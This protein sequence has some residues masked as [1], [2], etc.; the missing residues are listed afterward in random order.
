MDRAARP[1]FDSRIKEAVRT[2]ALRSPS[3]EVCGLLYS[4]ST[5]CTNDVTG[6][7]RLPNSSP[8]PQLHFAITQRDLLR[9][10]DW[11]AFRDAVPIGTFHSHPGG[12][13]RASGR[14]RRMIRRVGGLHA[15]VGGKGEIRFYRSGPC[16]IS[17]LE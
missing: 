15:I 1:N 9:A 8:L 11:L 16:R 12:E 6:A 14:D 2:A 7:L 10:L 4:R 5:A 13:A 3:A 17:R